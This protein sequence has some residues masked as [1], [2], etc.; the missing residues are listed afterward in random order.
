MMTVGDKIKHIR[1][2]RNLTQ[3]ELGIKSGFSASTADVRIRQY[4][5]NK[6]IP[7][8]NKLAQIA[9]ALDVDISALSNI[10]INSYEDIMH[11]LFELEDKIGLNIEK[12]GEKILLSINNQDI[13]HQLL[14]SYLNS[15]YFQKKTFLSNNDKK[16]SFENKID[17]EIW[18]ARFPLDLKKDWQ[19]QLDYISEFYSP[20]IK[21]VNENRH[22]ITKKSELI[23]QLR[24]IIETGIK[25]NFYTIHLG[26]GNGALVI[27][28][29]TSQL[30]TESQKIN[31]CIAEFM[32][33]LNTLKNYGMNIQVDLSLKD[34]ETYIDYKLFLSSLTPLA[35]DMNEIKEYI[36]NMNTL[37]DS[38]KRD[39]ETLYKQKLT[40]FDLNL[41]QEINFY[42][43]EK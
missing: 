11:I 10:N 42:N 7:K 2:L 32:S 8:A 12:K 3:K 40:S 4:E 25:I 20:L 29:P 24:K 5:S 13:T 23:I 34:D 35:N 16:D 30:L 19:I 38:S 15:W 43:K 28:L 36:T 27:S 6:M 1:N 26:I 9:S 33:D 17:Y 18:K 39:F 14:I 41:K 37:S 31:T 22:C 21:E